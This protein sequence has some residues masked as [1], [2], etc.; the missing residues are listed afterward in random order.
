MNLDDLIA[1]ENLLKSGLTALSLKILVEGIQ[2][3]L[4]STF[5][6]EFS[7]QYLWFSF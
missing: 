2:A 5:V 1:C 3:I 4:S 7:M 6:L